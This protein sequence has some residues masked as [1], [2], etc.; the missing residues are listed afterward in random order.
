MQISIRMEYTTTHDLE[1]PTSDGR[2][3]LFDVA[4]AI[5]GG[6]ILEN[7]DRHVS[8]SV[9]GT[10]HKY[11][12][13]MPLLN[14]S[15]LEGATIT[16]YASSTDFSMPE[17][18]LSNDRGSF[19]TLCGV[20][21]TQRRNLSVDLDASADS[22]TPSRVLKALR[23]QHSDKIPTNATLLIPLIS[24]SL[25]TS[26]LSARLRGVRLDEKCEVAIPISAFN[27]TVTYVIIDKPKVKASPEASAGAEGTGVAASTATTGAGVGAGVAVTT[28]TEDAS[29]GA[30]V[31]V[32]TAIAPTAGYGSALGSM[33]EGT[34][35]AFSS[36]LN[37]RIRTATAKAALRD[38][39]VTDDIETGTPGATDTTTPPSWVEREAARNLNRDVTPHRG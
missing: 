9:N 7:P 19:H 8:I 11:R 22:V 38:A 3:S 37:P 24:R 17:P 28:A 20:S 2:I 6:G 25:M 18:K 5:R 36:L 29:A 1:V 12:P 14:I 39:E 27:T 4:E 34:A 30:G 21:V 10:E 13:E 31:A 26:E 23:E 16:A 32:T 35:R 33:I 15:E